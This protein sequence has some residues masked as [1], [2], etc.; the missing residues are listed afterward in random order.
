MPP[1]ASPVFTSKRFLLE[2][3][4]GLLV[5]PPDHGHASLVQFPSAMADLVA[6]RDNEVYLTNLDHEQIT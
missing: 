3:R 4:I 5:S 2:V 1:T 6:S